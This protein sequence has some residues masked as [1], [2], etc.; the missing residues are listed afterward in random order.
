MKKWEIR[1]GILIA[2]AG[3]SL[4]TSG[5]AL[6]LVGGGAA[7]G[8]AIAKDTAGSFTDVSFDK[9]WKAAESV[10]RKEGLLTLSD[11]NH[12]YIEAQV[13]ESTVKVN[14]EQVTKD[15]VRINIKARKIKG[16]FPNVKLAQRLHLQVIDKIQ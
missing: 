6:F 13:E 2:F 7:G 10:I 5:C 11:K 4:L 16:L 8:Y 9:V 1:F 15:T 14:L 3:L 12:G